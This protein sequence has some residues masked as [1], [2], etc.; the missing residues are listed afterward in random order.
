MFCN[1]CIYRFILLN[2]RI[3]ASGFELH[4]FRN[5]GT[6]IFINEMRN[7]VWFFSLFKLALLNSNISKFQIPNNK[8]GF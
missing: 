8:V 1:G 2:L 7:L 4:S 5:L 3:D 6:H